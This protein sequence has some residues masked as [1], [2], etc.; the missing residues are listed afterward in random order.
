MST[1]SSG[2]GRESPGSGK[3][4]GKR[5]PHKLTTLES[6]RLR[7]L[8]PPKQEYEKVHFEDERT[9]MRLGFPLFKENEIACFAHEM[10]ARELIVVDMDNDCETDDEQIRKSKRALA[11]HVLETAQKYLD[12]PRSV[13]I[14]GV[15]VPVPARKRVRE[16]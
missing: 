8:P 15:F 5:T 16:E 6:I 10:H 14:R 13:D 9:H 4:T 3:R 2:T 7:V 12:K 11:V 1:R